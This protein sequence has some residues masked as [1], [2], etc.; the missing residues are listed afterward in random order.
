MQFRLK[1]FA[2]QIKGKILD[3]GAGTQPYRKLFQVDKYIATNTKRHYDDPTNFEKY[4]D[5]WI[6]DAS[7]LPF[8]S[9]EMDAIICFQVISVIEDPKKFF[10]EVKRILKPGGKFILTSDWL[11]P[12]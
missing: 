8:N 11:Y 2:T 9:N 4:T 6:E 12:T 1:P 10:I 3:I 7:T 5:V